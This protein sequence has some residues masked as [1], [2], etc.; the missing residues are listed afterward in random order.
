MIFLFFLLHFCESA[1]LV[2]FDISNNALFKCENCIYGPVRFNTSFNFF[3]N[4]FDKIY[5]H[6]DGFVS[7][8]QC[9]KLNSSENAI[10]IFTTNEFIS[11]RVYYKEI[12]DYYLLNKYSQHVRY[13]H[14]Y[15]FCA[16]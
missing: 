14:D 10:S 2:S 3:G 5:I 16:T 8:D 6:N 7:F 15:Y 13:K 4:I 11:G 1:Q 12:K 9:D